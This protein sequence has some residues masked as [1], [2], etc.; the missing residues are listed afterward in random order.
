MHAMCQGRGCAGLWHASTGV[1]PVLAPHA[2]NSSTACS[3]HQIPS[4][5]SLQLPST[6]AAEFFDEVG[7]SSSPRSSSAPSSREDGGSGSGSGSGS[8]GGGGA[9]QW[10]QRALGKLQRFHQLKDESSIR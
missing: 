5:V 8:G 10:S 9:I 6:Q 1:L 3:V 7:G 2:P 4:C